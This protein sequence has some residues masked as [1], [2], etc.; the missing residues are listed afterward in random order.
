MTSVSSI[1]LFNS[2]SS[3]LAA[4]A[5]T[6]LPFTEVD[7]LLRSLGASPTSVVMVVFNDTEHTVVASLARCGAN[8]TI[9]G[10]PRLNPASIF[11]SCNPGVVWIGQWLAKNVAAVQ[12]WVV[13]QHDGVVWDIFPVVLAGGVQFFVIISTLL[14]EIY[15]AVDAVNA[16]ATEQLS[17][18]RCCVY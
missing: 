4:V 16:L 17:V 13:Q 15:G 18:L 12:S 10:D 9:P 2:S 6:I 14:T 5:S 8:E 7:D 3:T 1:S 11:R